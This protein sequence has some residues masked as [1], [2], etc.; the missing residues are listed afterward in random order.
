[1]VDLFQSYRILELGAQETKLVLQLLYRIDPERAFSDEY[2]I[3]SRRR[4]KAREQSDDA[5]HVFELHEL[6]LTKVPHACC[7]EVPSDDQQ[8]YL[9]A[10]RS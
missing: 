2:S 7:A 5:L 6:V 8:H 3:R 4:V 1:M 10:T 9:Q